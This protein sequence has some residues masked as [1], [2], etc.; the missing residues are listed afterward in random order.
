[1]FKLNRFV[2]VDKNLS[3]LPLSRS[4]IPLTVSGVRL[5]RV[6]FLMQFHPLF[7]CVCTLWFSIHFSCSLFEFRLSDFS[8]YLMLL[9]SHSLPR[10]FF[11]FLH[12]QFRA[13]YLLFHS[14]RNKFCKDF[15]R[16]I[17]LF[18]LLGFVFF[19]SFC[20]LRLCFVS[21]GFLCVC[22]HSL[23]LPFVLTYRILEDTLQTNPIGCHVINQ[24]RKK[25][26]RRNEK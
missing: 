7:A 17:F 12:S 2:T 15:H 13:I 11:H 24:R 5:S 23:D 10:T 16:V 19:L 8:A 14:Q 1:M 9:Y 18:G 4:Q 21:S 6:F 3:S 20:C 22:V 25:N 26:I